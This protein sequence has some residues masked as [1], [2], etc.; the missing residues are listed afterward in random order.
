MECSRLTVGADHKALRVDFVLKNVSARGRIPRTNKEK[1]RGWRP[2]DAEHYQ[3]DVRE[4]LKEVI[5]DSSLQRDLEDR[6]H[7]IETTL[8]AIAIDCATEETRAAEEI[9]E[10]SKKLHEIIT[11]KA[12]RDA[13]GSGEVKQI[14]KD[15]QK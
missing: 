13:R 12:A 11:R 10:L 7:K 3:H 2:K 15:M 4:K 8:K 1:L 14:S 6:C 9:N 5:V